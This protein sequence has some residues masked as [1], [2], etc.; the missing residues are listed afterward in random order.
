MG[1]W[2]LPEVKNTVWERSG[3]W[4]ELSVRQQSLP[5][6]EPVFA[7]APPSRLACSHLSRPR[8]APTSSVG[9]AAP[10]SLP[11]PPD[12]LGNCH[13][14]SAEGSQAELAGSGGKPMT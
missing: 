3:S 5:S 2:S 8:C 14:A 1:K 7:V 4:G 12:L 6:P 13:S 9:C 11:S 10:R